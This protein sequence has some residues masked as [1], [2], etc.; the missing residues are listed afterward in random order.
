MERGHD[1]RDFCLV[2]FGG[3]GPLHA[4]ALAESLG[5]RRML[6]PRFPG[7]TSALGL[8]LSDVAREYSRTV[9]VAAPAAGGDDLEQGF[10]ALE[11]TARADLHAEGIAPRRTELRRLLDMR[12]VGQSYELPV[13]LRALDL[14]RAAADF[15]A[16]HAQR[17]GYSRPEAPVE[18]VNLRLKAIGGAARLRLRPEAETP[19]ATPDAALRERRKVIVD[20]PERVPVYDRDLLAPG[21]AWLG[22]ALVVQSD[23]TFLLH[24]GWQARVDGY[25]NIIAALS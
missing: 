20:A 1:V 12:Y 5:I 4:C 19:G 8:L 15:H 22:P 14:P 24:P 2:A 17:F 21:A 18:V 3:G 23:S 10:A 13:P 6:V 7:A 11:E 25:G 16:L 9:M